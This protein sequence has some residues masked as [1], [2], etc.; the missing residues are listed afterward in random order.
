MHITGDYIKQHQSRILVLA[1]ISRLKSSRKQ[2]I[3][4]TLQIKKNDL[5]LQP[6]DG[7]GMIQTFQKESKDKKCAKHC[8][9]SSM[10]I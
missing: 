4:I 5:Y 1:P 8:S 9:I 6:F 2:N 3:Q 7:I 10:Q